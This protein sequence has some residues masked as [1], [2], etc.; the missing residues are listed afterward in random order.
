MDQYRRYYGVITFFAVAILALYG[1]YA[2]IYPKFLERKDVISKLENKQ[3]TLESKSR[4]Q[5]VVENKI[6]KIK[7]SIVSSQ[8]KFLYL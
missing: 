6:K 3:K 4:E 8:K 2:V 5:R 7:D 1:S